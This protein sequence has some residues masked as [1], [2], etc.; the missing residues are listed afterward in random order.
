MRFSDDTI[1]FGPANNAQLIRLYHNAACSVSPSLMEG[2]GLP[3]IESVYCGILPVISD[4]PVYREIWADTVSYFDPYDINS[5]AASVLK[6]INLPKKEYMEK[7]KNAQK[8]LKN[9]SWRKSAQTT[10]DQYS[11]IYTSR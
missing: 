1:F 9:F 3:N 7:V 5:I 2:F 11:K 6:I 4:I 10:L 8:K